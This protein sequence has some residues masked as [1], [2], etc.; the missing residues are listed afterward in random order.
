MRDNPNVSTTGIS[1]CLHTEYGLVVL[2]IRF[3]PIGYDLNAAVY[4]AVCSEGE[5]YFVKV[6]IGEIRTFA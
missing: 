1:E 4:E 5:T 6:R 2:N 3:L